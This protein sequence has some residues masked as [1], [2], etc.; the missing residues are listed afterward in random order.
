VPD[1]ARLFGQP[2][3]SPVDELL[4]HFVR[5]LHDLG[6]LLLDRYEG[7][8]QALVAAANGRAERFVELLLDMPM[9]RDV[10]SYRGKEIWI[11]KRA[12]LTPADVAL[13]LGGSELGRLEGLD[14]LT[15]FADNL[16]PHVLRME[17][18]LVYDP[19]LLRA[20]NA[21]EALEA[22]G[23]AEVE[24]R[25]VSIHA[26]EGMLA[27]L[28]RLG[29]ATTAWEIDYLLWQAGQAPKYKAQ[30]RHRSRSV[31]Y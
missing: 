7:S 30:P 17:G 25:A 19:E 4:A 18:V 5:A 29:Q 24:I 2:L 27:L 11:L 6:R 22:G 14:R 12:Q 1:C 31:Y 28:D 8:F 13:A 9:Y 23:G 26:V 21:G 20:I 3:R 15:I 16:V 10:A